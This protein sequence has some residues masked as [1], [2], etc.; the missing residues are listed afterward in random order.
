MARLRGL[1]AS[2]CGCPASLGHGLALLPGIP[3]NGSAHQMGS[4]RTERTRRDIERK[5]K[6]GVRWGRHTYINYSSFVE[7]WV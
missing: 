7:G 4:H 6:V 1:G 5:R 2:R 3:L